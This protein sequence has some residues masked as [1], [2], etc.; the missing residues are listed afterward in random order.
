MLTWREIPGWMTPEVRTNLDALIMRYNVRSVCEIGSFLGRSAVWFSQHELIERVFCVDTW[1]E[2]ADT[3]DVNN[4][5]W[6]LAHWSL[7][8]D[9]F[10][11]FREHVWR[12]GAFDKVIPIRGDSRDVHPLVEPV[13]LVYIDGDHSYAGCAS[14]IRLY[15]PK[16]RRVIC[17]DDFADAFEGV[18]RA[19]CDLTVEEV[20]NAD[21]RFWWI[22]KE[23]DREWRLG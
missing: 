12:A 10:S 8:R 7:P 2:F 17:G 4:L 6:T 5:V 11:F 20:L 21:G 13:D 3:P 14:D 16:A 19:T 22:E 23:D 15:G 1:T 9:F 18:R